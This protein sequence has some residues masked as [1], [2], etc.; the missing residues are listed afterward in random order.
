MRIYCPS[1]TISPWYLSTRAARIPCA[2]AVHGDAFKW[3]QAS[4]AAQDAMAQLDGPFSAAETQAKVLLATMGS[5][6]S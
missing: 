5:N 4:V 6:A 2:R 1:D 3:N